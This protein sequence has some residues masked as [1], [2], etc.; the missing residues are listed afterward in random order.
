MCFSNVTS[1]WHTQPT[2]NWV[3]YI[4]PC[5]LDLLCQSFSTMRA[6]EQQ[7]FQRHDGVK[8]DVV[9]SEI[10]Q[11]NN[12]SIDYFLVEDF[13]GFRLTYGDDREVHARPYS[14]KLIMI[15]LKKNLQASHSSKVII[16][17]IGSEL[18]ITLSCTLQYPVLW[19]M[20]CSCMP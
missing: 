13:F 16:G 19:P 10:M 8:T 14:L 1:T 7:S 5:G 18:K 20:R 17:N 6:S 2:M 12:P 9:M 3:L 11:K 4:L 15:D